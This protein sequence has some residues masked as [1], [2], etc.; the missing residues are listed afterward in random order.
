MF[1]GRKLVLQYTDGSPCDPPKKHKLR[2]LDGR[3]GTLATKSLL[4]RAPRRHNDDDDDD[5]DDDKHHKDKNKSKDNEEE[6]RKS[7]TISLL[8]ERDPLA[9]MASVAFVGASPDECAYFFELRSQHACGGVSNSQQPL[10]PGGVFGVMSVSPKR[11]V[12][13]E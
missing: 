4:Q 13:E 6:R 10:G 1:R 12:L 11:Y 5:E 9:P 7:T 8:C 3:D 2:S